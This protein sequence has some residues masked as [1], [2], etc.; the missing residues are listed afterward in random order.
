M[1]LGGGAC[2]KKWLSKGGG[3][4]SQKNKGK[5]GDHVKYKTLKWH[6]VKNKHRRQETNYYK[7]SFASIATK[8]YL[9]LLNLKTCR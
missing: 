2:K 9:Y 1:G 8:K 6:N 7:L 4:A 3:G 5:K